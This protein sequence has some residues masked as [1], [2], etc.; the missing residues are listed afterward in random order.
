MQACQ[1][2][3]AMDSFVNPWSPCLCRGWSASSPRWWQGQG[4]E[5]KGLCK[6]LVEVTWGIAGCYVGIHVAIW[7]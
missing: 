7:H 3:P 1:E 4:L 2:T 6:I 5:G